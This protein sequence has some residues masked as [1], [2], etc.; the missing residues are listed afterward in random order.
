MSPNQTNDAVYDVN[1][2]VAP[3]APFFFTNDKP[4]AHRAQRRT[5]RRTT[6]HTSPHNDAHIAAKMESSELDL[7]LLTDYEGFFEFE[8]EPEPEPKPSSS[9]LPLIAKPAPLL[10]PLAPRPPD[11]V[12]AILTT[13]ILFPQPPIVTS[14]AVLQARIRRAQAKKRW[15][16][17]RAR[18]LKSPQHF[19]EY[20]CRR[21]V[22]N[23]RPR[24]NGRFIRENT[25]EWVPVC[26]LP[27]VTDAAPV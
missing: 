6:T 14:R 8:P 23:R 3:V 15:L 5:H 26:D 10:V 13:P 9:L 1:E 27:P 2:R 25:R 20:Q 18:R 11:L 12:C 24:V 7:D 4:L 17:K 16:E 22:A 21:V 19:P